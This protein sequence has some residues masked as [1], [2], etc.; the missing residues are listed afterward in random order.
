MSEEKKFYVYSKPGCGFCE[1]LTGFMDNH[2]ILYEKF[3]LGSDYTEEE[4][5]IK[6]GS[7]STFPQVSYCGGTIGGMHD[8]IRYMQRRKLI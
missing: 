4:F 3:I 1:K 5:L 7:N 8:T 2:D 6:F